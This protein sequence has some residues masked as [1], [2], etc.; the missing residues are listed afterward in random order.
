MGLLETSRLIE[1]NKGTGV[2]TSLITLVL[3]AVVP[4]LL[5]GSAVCWMVI[6]QK[7]TAITRELS[8]TARALGVAVDHHLLSQFAGME[9]LASDAS[10]YPSNP[11]DFQKR[12]DLVLKANTDWLAVALIDPVTHQII[13]SSP[14]LQRAP[15]ATLAPE[16]ENRIVKTGKPLIVGAYRSS[17][18][19]NSPMILL[20]AP[21]L[22]ERRVRYVLG[23]ALNPKTVADLFKE[24][25]F[26]P[27]W[28][29]A[30]LDNGMK[31]AGRSREQNH[32]VGVQATKTLRDGMGN[33]FS[34]MF[35]TVTLDGTAVYTVFSHSALTDWSVVIGVPSAEVERPIQ[36]ILLKL[37]AASSV[38]LAFALVLAGIVG[39]GI[40]RRRKAYESAIT[41][42]ES[43]FRSMA[44]SAPV[45]IWIC[46]TDQLCSWFNQVWLDFTGKE[47]AQELGDGWLEG[48]HPEDRGRCLETLK[49]AFDD[50]RPFSIEYRLRRAD[51]QYRW[52]LDNGSPRYDEQRIFTG[53]IGSC[54]DITEGKD[55]AELLKSSEERYRSLFEMGAD[56]ILMV[57]W[58]TGRI[59]DHNAAALNMYGYSKEEFAR[60]TP[61]DLSAEPSVTEGSIRNRDALVH[62]RKHRKKDGSVFPV[63]IHC[64]YFSYRERKVFVAA[65]R[66]ISDRIQ[67]ESAFK[68]ISE[69]HS[70]ILE[71]AGVGI[72]Y[73]KSRCFTW[74][75][76]T[77]CRM[78][79][80]SGR[81]DQCPYLHDLPFRGGV[82]ANRRGSLPGTGDREDIHQRTAVAPQRRHL[83]PR[84]LQRQGGGPGG[85]GGR[86][87]LDNFRRNLP[88]RA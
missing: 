68:K 46:G 42:S 11:A 17:K 22:R 57:D 82:R 49:G 10:L 6:D 72:A 86:E 70:I 40:V 77:F 87:H 21:V 8:N 13:A 66:D 41:E 28:T 20:L 80:Y 76:S 5:F 18:I 74:A 55:A 85:P 83:V 24:Q 31:V 29:G 3:V 53:Y 27:S 14:P 51:G 71:N 9:L 4:L 19:V 15:I 73:V 65:S 48:V 44:N 58:E 67:A 12:A 63:E 37:L 35:K 30:V 16:S 36:R 39:R 1:K 32:Y 75:N 50:R 78:L 43:R 54:T 34:G 61:L 23:V 26:T 79:G 56:A 60:L 45:L 69:E 52:L 59:I 64:A 62:L 25:Q 38:L 47:L 84:A 81:T 33:K 2:G 88:L 7:K